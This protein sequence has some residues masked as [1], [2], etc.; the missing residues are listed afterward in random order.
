MQER[1]VATNTSAVADYEPP[2]GLHSGATPANPGVRKGL[3]LWGFLEAALKWRRGR[4]PPSISS[5]PP[6][7]L[8]KQRLRRV[9]GYFVDYIADDFLPRPIHSPKMAT[10]AQARNALCDAW[11]RASRLVWQFRVPAESRKRPARHR[12]GWRRLRGIGTAPHSHR[13]GIVTRS[14]T[15]RC[16][17][18]RREVGGVVASTASPGSNFVRPPRLRFP[19]QS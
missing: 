6:V 3:I 19:H 12:G 13:A 4:D 2:L 18:A 5:T 17:P 8:K 1:S 14:E 11:L 10:T 16:R 7:F 9:T 15:I